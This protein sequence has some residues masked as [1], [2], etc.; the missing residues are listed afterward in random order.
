MHGAVSASGRSGSIYE[1]KKGDTLTSISKQQGST[2]D[3]LRVVNNLKDDVIYPDQQLWVPVTYE[4]Q[5]GDTLFQIA[6]RFKTTI[7]DVLKVNYIKDQ[8]SIKAGRHILEGVG[9]GC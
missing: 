1:V 4:I 3:V 6:K 2:I 9:K 7:G 8:N 5:K